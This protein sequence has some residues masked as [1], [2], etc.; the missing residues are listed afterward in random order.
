MAAN[1]KEEAP[2]VS[3]IGSVVPEEPEEVA[4]PAVQATETGAAR[5]VWI[6]DAANCVALMLTPF[7]VLWRL[8][9]LNPHDRAFIWQ[10]VTDYVYP[11]F[12]FLRDSFVLHGELPKWT[13]AVY[14]GLPFSGNFMNVVMYPP[15]L[16]FLLIPSLDPAQPE[17]FHAYMIAHIST[18]AVGFYLL[19]R[20]FHLRRPISLLGASIYAF[21]GFTNYTL[22]TGTTWL[23]PLA[24]FPF[25]LLTARMLVVRG[26]FRWAAMV[27][28]AAFLFV[29]SSNPLTA[30][31]GLMF[32]TIFVVTCVWI[33]RGGRNSWSLITAFVTAVA[34]GILLHAYELLPLAEMTQSV[35]G[36]QTPSY[37]WTRDKWFD[38]TFLHFLSGFLFGGDIDKALVYFGAAGGLAVAAG[39]WLRGGRYW[40]LW[41]ATFLLSVVACFAS[42]DSFLYDLVYLAVP[43]AKKLPAIGRGGGL[44]VTTAAAFLAMTAIRNVGRIRRELRPT[45]AALL[46][47]A[48]SAILL[49]LLYRP[50]TA[51]EVAAFS[52]SFTAWLVSATTLLFLV[53]AA[54]P[55]TKRKA[56]LLM[57]AV[58]I[59]LGTFSVV[60]RTF[61]PRLTP[62]SQKEASSMKDAKPDT[63]AAILYTSPYL[64]GRKSTP[65][66]PSVLQPRINS[67]RN[68]VVLLEGPDNVGGYYP[69][70]NR[71]VAQAF[72][73]AGFQDSYL[74]MSPTHTTDLKIRWPE[75]SVAHLYHLKGGLG[76]A[77]VVPE[78]VFAKSPPL[79]QMAAAGFDPAR[80]VYLED[81]EA[82]LQE[83]FGRTFRA[84]ERLVGALMPQQ[85]P[86]PGATG[87]LPAINADLSLVRQTPNSIAFRLERDVNQQTLFLSDTWH[88]G[89]ACYVN[90][91]R[92]PLFVADYVF[93][94]VRLNAKESSVVEFVY[95]PPLVMLGGILS[96]LIAILF[97]I[98]TILTWRKNI[99]AERLQAS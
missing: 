47:F 39:L 87:K 78:A 82:V 3:S 51:A 76:R 17:I 7:V 69:W 33:E 85:R 14:G 11:F 38:Q 60:T 41:A 5:S 4:S 24:W 25:L 50:V 84:L 70:V 13:W 79:Q 15:N 6:P 28:G 46:T 63:P 64:G 61:E 95:D 27:V 89:W 34:F 71:R 93:K 30:I 26:T 88:P 96:A 8:W 49:W 67:T 32:A 98:I 68:N 43:G 83:Q 91:K 74:F 9:T 48:A 31:P 44:L 92:V 37:L 62:L 59:V 22:L 72:S 16:L 18:A 52:Q 57:A 75:K 45:L 73:A 2:R 36:Y 77:W 65:K 55:G 53:L 10:D 1:V 42:R 81:E 12:V 20:A 80:V 94:A 40:T 97:I 56:V 23:V 54:G 90:G 19:A 21:N 35:Q 29:A 66:L 58:M 86:V 99:A